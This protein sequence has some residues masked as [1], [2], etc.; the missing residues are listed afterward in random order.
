M[1]IYPYSAS[2]MP[3]IVA[4]GSVSSTYQGGQFNDFLDDWGSVSLGK[5]HTLIGGAGDDIYWTSVTT[6]GVI[7]ESVNGGTDTVFCSATSSFV[8]DY[9][10]PENVENL[11]V[12]GGSSTLRT[13][14]G[15]ALN[16]R[17]I[18]G[19]SS[20]YFQGLGGNDTVYSG[21]GGD[22]VYGGVGNDLVDG[23]LGND[24]LLGDDGNDTIFGGAGLDT[25]DGGLGNDIYY[26]S[27]YDTASDAGGKTDVLYFDAVSQSA[28]YAAALAANPAALPVASYTVGAGIEKI[29]LSADSS[30]VNIVANAENNTILGDARPNSLDGGA[31]NDTM[32]GGLLAD[33]LA[34]G[35][36]NDLYTWDGSDTI[37][38]SVDG[39]VDTLTVLSPVVSTFTLS[40]N[41]DNLIFSSKLTAGYTVTGNDTANKITTSSG[42]DSI[43]GAGGNDVVS[44]G[45]GID[46]VFGGAGN[47]SIS[48]TKGVGYLLGGDGNDS[49]TVGT[50]ADFV[51][52]GAGIDKIS[53]GNDAATDTLH[54]LVTEIG[55]DT[56]SYFN[57]ASDHIL[58]TA[59]AVDLSVLPTF[60]AVSVDDFVASATGQPVDATDRF[61]FNT[62][63]HH[64]YYD[65][66]GN[67]A[68]TAIDL[69]NLS[70]VSALSATAIQ[71]VG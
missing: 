49:L 54:F 32:D 69:V 3:L 22:T 21:L 28:H 18:M 37:I 56:V 34:G 35:L 26:V 61:L 10:L 12:D 44:P 52:G 68:G 53:L 25:I 48:D 1:A 62:T 5:I 14:V 59:A 55:T 64:L 31:G 58:L 39:G 27:G 16:N 47:D 9:V 43:S 2:I 66:D 23:G 60:S 30:V 4:N 45:A 17:A 36:G 38:E 41:T 13:Y 57:P 63:N 46:T 8:G 67:G 7:V 51:S 33:T 11:I 40:D 20:D 29:T 42:N 19:M 71:F 70:G 15:N 50:D 65:A 24:S 6:G